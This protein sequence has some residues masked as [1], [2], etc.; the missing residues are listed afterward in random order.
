M[1]LQDAELMAGPHWVDRARLGKC[2]EPV[3]IDER[4]NEKDAFKKSVLS[5]NLGL[6]WSHSDSTTWVVFHGE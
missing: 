5:C 1:S 3:S 2:D 4:I 6:F